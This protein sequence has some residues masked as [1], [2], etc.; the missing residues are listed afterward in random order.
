MLMFEV[1]IGFVATFWAWFLTIVDRVLYFLIIFPYSIA[2][3][4]VHAIRKKFK[5]KK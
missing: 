3:A 5:K 2:A 1:F 4:L